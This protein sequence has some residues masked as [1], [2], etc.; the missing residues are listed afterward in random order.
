MIFIIT[1]IYSI[2]PYKK[3]NSNITTNQILENF[4]G[5]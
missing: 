4:D 1:F 3:S 2:K 5:Y